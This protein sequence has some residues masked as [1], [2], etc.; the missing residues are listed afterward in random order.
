MADDKTYSYM[1]SPGDVPSSGNK[2]QVGD[3]SGPL[4]YADPGVVKYGTYPEPPE[5]YDK[6]QYAEGENI[7]TSDVGTGKYP[8]VGPGMVPRDYNVP[9]PPPLRTPEGTFSLNKT[10]VSP[11]SAGYSR[12]YNRYAGHLDP[13]YA[14]GLATQHE[15][16]VGGSHTGATQRA[17]RDQFLKRRRE[18]FTVLGGEQYDTLESYAMD[19]F[20]EIPKMDLKEFQAIV[21]DDFGIGFPIES[22]L[23]TPLAPSIEEMT[24]EYD[25]TL[26]PQPKVSLTEARQA[27]NLSATGQ[28]EYASGPG[29]N[30]GGGEKKEER[31]LPHWGDWGDPQDP[32]P[33]W[34]VLTDSGYQH[35]NTEQAAKDAAAYVKKKDGGEVRKYQDGTVD[36]G[37]I[38][39]ERMD[40]IDEAGAAPASA[41]ADDVPLEAREGDVVFPPESVEVMGL[42]NMN[43]MIKAALGL[44]LEIGAVVPAEIDPNEKVPVKL[45]N[46]EVI[47]PKVVADAVGKERVQEIIN[48]GLKLRAQREEEAAQAQQQPAPEAAPQVPESIPQ[49][50]QVMQEAQGSP[51]GLKDGS[52]SIGTQIGKLLNTTGEIYEDVKKNPSK[53]GQAVLS[54]VGDAFGLSQDSDL[55]TRAREAWSS[56]H[57]AEPDLLKETQF[58][59]HQTGKDDPELRKVIQGT[60]KNYYEEKDGQTIGDEGLNPTTVEEIMMRIAA[61]ETPGGETRQMIKENGKLVPKGRA[62]GRL[63]VEP[64]TARSMLTEAKKIIGPKV[65]G[66]LT[67]IFGVDKYEDIHALSNEQFNNVLQ[68]NPR[69]SV[70]FGILN[71]ITKLKRDK[72]LDL[73]R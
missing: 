52:S 68:N 67:E 36:V 18:E 30:Q 69:A 43:D 3:P 50:A 27:A 32:L 41:L 62:R 48:K 54:E 47:I 29:P 35:F 66:S 58:V 28:R 1:Y 20:N 61:H 19:K 15:K 13:R 38:E 6:Y 40:F 26:P 60:L 70:E 39:P 45:T 22:G 53:W 7:I 21:Q 56:Y 5:G 46:G 55:D 57:G 23:K 17:I 72:K 51:Q 25:A 11:P 59:L 71:L 16:F 73:L 12:D 9:P 8:N 24:K 63:Q 14:G 37:S 64:T 33:R 2:Y 10:P 65:K 49:E 31:Y 4:P 44:A 34:R 42:L